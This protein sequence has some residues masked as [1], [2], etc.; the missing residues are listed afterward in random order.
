MSTSVSAKLHALQANPAV[1]LAEYNSAAVADALVALLQKA[2][3][4]YYNSEPILT[5][6]VFDI[7]QDHLRAIAPNHVYLGV[8]GAPETDK[9]ELPYWMGSLDKIKDDGEKVI[10]KFKD[11]YPGPYVVSHKLDGNSGLLVYA[12]DVK[13]YSRGD[14]SEGQD[15]SNMLKYIKVPSAKS[16]KSKGPVAVRGELIISKSNWEEISDKGSNARNVVAGA[17]HAKKPEAT[18]ASRIDFV[19]Y[20]L[21]EPKLPFSEGLEFMQKAGFKVVEWS[22]IVSKNLTIDHLSDILVKERETSE[23]EIDGIVITQDAEHKIIRGKNP[24]YAFAFKSILTHTEA[25]VLVSGVEWRVSKDGY[26]KPTIVFPG[27]TIA[28][29]NIQRATGNN[30]SFIVKNGIGAGA[31]I[32]IIRSGDVIPKV[33]R[34]TKP[35]KPLMPDMAYKWND[36]EV[37]IMVDGDGMTEEQ[38]LRNLEHFMKSLSIKHVAA[39]ILKRL[40]DAGHDSVAALLKLTVDDVA[41]IDGFKKT[42]AT[43]VVTAIQKIRQASCVDLMVA[44][45]RF[46]RGL[47]EKKIHTI[48]KALPKIL[49]GKAPTHAELR[50]IEGIGDAT[51]KGFLS[52]LS[53]FFEFMDEIGIPCSAV[54]AQTA[55]PASASASASASKKVAE[56]RASAAAAATATDFTGQVVVFTGFR[57]KDWEAAVEAAGGKVSG[58]VSSKTTLVVAADPHESSTKITKAKDLGIK[59]ISMTEFGLMVDV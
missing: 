38:K 25:E 1:V 45:N 8:V 40:V 26:I 4:A 48:V 11:K 49:E 39:G 27:V 57:N 44:S 50:G 52:G 12:N 58:S 56:P 46:G 33:I 30:A 2:T 47:G 16:L 22:S 55:A 24:K 31:R 19:V 21:L 36:T 3:D 23:Y 29:V 42:S 15:L 6:E 32:V 53:A 13:L 28:G 17:M 59:V 41:A 14:G 18:I 51:A 20:E 5:D 54:S 10:T 34:V 7:A 35:A 9:V 43:T 37:D